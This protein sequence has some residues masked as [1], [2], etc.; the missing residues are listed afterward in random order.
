MSNTTKQLAKYY[1][2]NNPP[3]VKQVTQDILNMARTYIVKLPYNETMTNE[4]IKLLFEEYYP[5]GKVTDVEQYKHV[6]RDGSFVT[7]AFVRFLWT[8]CGGPLLK[9]IHDA[10]LYYGCCESWVVYETGNGV[11]IKIYYDFDAELVAKMPENYV[12]INKKTEKILNSLMARINELEKPKVE[13]EPEKSSDELL[14]RID[15]LEKANA[16]LAEQ[17]KWM[18]KGLYQKFMYMEKVVD[19]LKEAESN[20]RRRRR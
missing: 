3:V 14:S 19:E 7:V 6:N 4:Y 12:N 11:Q 8:Y 15:I 5:I 1:M 10:I 20:R 9:N 18:N 17:V 13:P 2:T 16:E